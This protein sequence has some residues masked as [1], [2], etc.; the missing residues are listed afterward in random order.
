[1]RKP[2]ST[3][4]SGRAQAALDRGNGFTLIELLAT[5]A[6]LGVL[7]VLLFS[8][9]KPALG[10][11]KSARCLANLRVCGAALLAQAADNNGRAALAW[12]GAASDL[13][14]YPDLAGSSQFGQSW[15]QY[16]KKTGYL[17]DIKMAACPAVSPYRYRDESGFTLQAYGLRRWNTEPYKPSAVL[18]SV[19]KP[20]AYVLL[21]DSVVWGGGSKPDKFPGQRYFITYPG[22]RVDRIHTRHGGRANIFFLDGSARGLT[23]KE[24]SDMDSGWSL[25]RSVDET[26][27]ER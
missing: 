25:D 7:A 22:N 8:V 20:S 19:D 10:A 2:P 15:M 4:S 21:A 27:Y 23:G 16:L 12:G 13:G 6:I 26:N 5:L 24:I 9:G 1:M 14:S 11:S 17:D 3:S 18:Q